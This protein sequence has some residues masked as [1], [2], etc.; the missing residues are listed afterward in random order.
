MTDNDKYVALLERIEMLERHVFRL[1]AVSRAMEHRVKALEDRT[2]VLVQ[3]AGGI[4]AKNC[5]FN[6]RLPLDE[7]EEPEE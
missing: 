2:G 5:T 7:D 3:T 6:G 4:E 1:D